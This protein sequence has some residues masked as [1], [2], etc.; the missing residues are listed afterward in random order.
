MVAKTGELRKVGESDAYVFWKVGDGG[1]EFTVEMERLYKAAWEMH[2]KMCHDDKI[3]AYRQVIP[4]VKKA[5]VAMGRTCDV[6]DNESVAQTLKN[7]I[8]KF[9]DGVSSKGQIAATVN[10]FLAAGHIIKGE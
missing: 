4:C 9:I 3:E 2:V 10:L 7:G 5:C 8:N 1:I 6:I